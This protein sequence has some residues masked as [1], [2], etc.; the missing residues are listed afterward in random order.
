MLVKSSILSA[1]LCVLLCATPAFAV[2]SVNQGG[3]TGN[4]GGGGGTGPSA[5]SPDGGGR[6]DNIDARSPRNESQRAA[7]ARG[8]VLSDDICTGGKYLSCDGGRGN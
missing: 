8:M 4:G 3:G 7:A 5:T 6:A 1:S 2:V